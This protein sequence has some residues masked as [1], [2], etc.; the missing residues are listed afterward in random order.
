MNR[1]KF[2]LESKVLIGTDSDSSFDVSVDRDLTSVFIMSLVLKGVDSFGSTSVERDFTNF[3]NGFA[4]A[5]EDEGTLNGTTDLDVESDAVAEIGVL[6]SEDKLVEFN[7]W[8]NKEDNGNVVIDEDGNVTDV[9]NNSEVVVVAEDGLE[10]VTA[11]D[12]AEELDEVAGSDKCWP[13]CLHTHTFSLSSGTKPL[14]FTSP[15]S[16][17][18]ES[19]NSSSSSSSS[20]LPKAEKCMVMVSLE[21]ER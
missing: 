3:M 10:N 17:V 5:V 11:V 21:T 12:I 6:I 7:G 2:I 15:G 14:S 18:E 13:P 16:I 8:S 20:S 19:S 9:S 1:C 4:L